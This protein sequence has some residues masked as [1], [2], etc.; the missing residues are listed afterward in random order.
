WRLDRP[1]TENNFL[2]LYARENGKAREPVKTVFS[3]IAVRRISV[4]EAETWM[5]AEEFVMAN[6][7]YDHPSMT[8]VKASRDAGDMAT[9]KSRLISY[10][11]LREKPKGPAYDLEMARA[12][13]H[14][15]EANWR[16]VSDYAIEGIYAKLLLEQALHSVPKINRVSSF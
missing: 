5:S 16:E 13:A 12:T 14:G 2:S 10:F 1:L 8:E 3:D 7:N 6:L 11:R 15:K 4:E 9:A